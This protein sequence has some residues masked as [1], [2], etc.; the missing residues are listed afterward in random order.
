MEGEPPG[1]PPYASRG[2]GDESSTV[3]MVGTKVPPTLIRRNLLM[4]YCKR[5]NEAYTHLHI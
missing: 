4:S 1:E 5:G 3:G 2:R